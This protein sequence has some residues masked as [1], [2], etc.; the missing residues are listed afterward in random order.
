MDNIIQTFIKSYG[1]SKKR[2]L[3]SIATYIESIEELGYEWEI[4][5]IDDQGNICK[6]HKEIEESIKCVIRSKKKK[7]NPFENQILRKSDNE[8][9]LQFRENIGDYK[10]AR[11]AEGFVVKV[12]WL[13]KDESLCET[14]EEIAASTMCKIVERE[15]TPEEYLK[16]QKLAIDN[17][18]KETKKTL[19]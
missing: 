19:S 4:E 9:M 18:I 14:E 1:E 13:N 10:V 8:S 16:E 2:F 15:K 17:Y 5:W 7:V 3:D 11:E 6:T 12:K